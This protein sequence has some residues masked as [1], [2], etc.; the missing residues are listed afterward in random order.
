MMTTKNTFLR[1]WI[2][3]PCDNPSGTV[4][5]QKTVPLLLG[6]DNHPENMVN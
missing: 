3:L 2:P 6:V 1:G 5:T 4:F